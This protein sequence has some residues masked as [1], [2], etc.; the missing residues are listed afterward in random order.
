VDRPAA[1]LDFNL[2]PTKK[3]GRSYF[4]EGT[5]YVELQDG[6]VLFLERW[7]SADLYFGRDENRRIEV[8]VSE[9][10]PPKFLRFLDE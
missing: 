5:W 1:D 9:G 8:E 3:E 6:K 10:N 4:N 2:M 7:P